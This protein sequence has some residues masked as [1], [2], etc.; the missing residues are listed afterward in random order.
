MDH[1]ATSTSFPISVGS[2]MTTIDTG[3]DDAATQRRK[4]LFGDCALIEIIHLHDCLRGAIKALEKDVIE[5]SHQSSVTNRHRFSVDGTISTI[6]KQESQLETLE[7]RVA[8]R[9]K[10]IWSVFRSHSSA[11]DEFI[12]P[13]L[14]S[15][16]Q[17][18]VKHSPK[19]EPGASPSSSLTLLNR[20][21][22]QQQIERV[23]NS[24][25][26]ANSAAEDNLIEQA[27]YE[28]DHASEEIMFET[29][30]ALLAKLRKGL[31]DQREVPVAVAT[32]SPPGRDTIHDTAL[33]L[34]QHTQSLS[35][36]LYQHLEKEE[37]QCMPL[38]LK[39]LTRSE[40]HDLVGNIMGKRSSAMISN[41]MTMAVQNLTSN[42]REEM[43]KY[44]KQAME[45]TFFDRWLLMSGWMQP[46]KESEKNE[47]VE[48]AASDLS[49]AAL[50]GNLDSKK[51]PAQELGAEDNAADDGKKMMIASSV[52]VSDPGAARGYAFKGA[53]I[54]GQ[55]ELERLIRAVASNPS[56]T[57]VQKNTTIQG[58]RDSVWKSNQKQREK[59]TG[60]AA[61][62]F[63]PQASFLTK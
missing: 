26:G 50:P 34:A 31:L 60:Q 3:D 16:T 23:K 52:P 27:E 13:A 44:M 11:E 8:G 58:L 63:A 14:Q 33:A 57:P 32:R 12:W 25:S 51:R 40:I 59:E 15:K 48:A 56:L 47:T 39:H 21:P 49:V 54:T 46:S 35:K 10:V 22:Q 4:K 28:E 29:I 7:R 36:H 37:T 9:L 45:G 55:S 43:I 17:G 53:N 62:D 18:R 61:H 30:D 24:E 20:Q 5:L 41:I 6:N 2:Q 42:E 1:D 19:Y 38:V